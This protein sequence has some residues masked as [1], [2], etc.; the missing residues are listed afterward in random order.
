LQAG[1]KSAGRTFVSFVRSIRLPADADLQTEGATSANVKNGVMRIGECQP[2]WLLFDAQVCI[3]RP[4]FAVFIFIVYGSYTYLTCIAVVVDLS[5]GLCD[6]AF[7]CTLAEMRKADGAKRTGTVN[8][9]VM[10]DSAVLKLCH[11]M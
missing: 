8:V 6:V 10:W 2:S 11:Y 4:R 5:R 9:P 7:K 3:F 1:A